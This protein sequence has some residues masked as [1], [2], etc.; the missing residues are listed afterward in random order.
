MKTNKKEKDWVD[1][2]VEAIES[3]GDLQLMLYLKGMLE[4]KFSKDRNVLFYN[5]G[6]SNK[7]HGSPLEV[8]DT[9]S[10]AIM[11]KFEEV[12]KNMYDKAVDNAKKR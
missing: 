1:K 7:Y 8:H 9:L 6:R 5:S 12:Y 11:S 4:N 10:N 2:K 3:W